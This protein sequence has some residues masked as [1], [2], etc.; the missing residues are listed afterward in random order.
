M[1]TNK[2]IPQVTLEEK[3]KQLEELQAKVDTV[4]A[5]AI[6]RKLNTLDFSIEVWLNAIL[7]KDAYV[8]IACRMI[9]YSTHFQSEELLKFM[10]Y[11]AN[12]TLEKNESIAH[13]AVDL[14][15]QGLIINNTLKEENESVKFDV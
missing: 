6:R 2:Q 3:Q 5:E 14:I 9:G 11:L 13:R 8:A 7:K 10:R 1:T 15:N 4:F 12:G